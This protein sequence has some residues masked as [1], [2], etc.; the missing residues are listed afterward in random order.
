MYSGQYKPSCEMS[1][2][3]KSCNQGPHY[4]LLNTTVGTGT[5]RQLKLGQF[6]RTRPIPT[7]DFNIERSDQYF[8]TYNVRISV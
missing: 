8:K 4:S 3:G 1:H 6:K 5:P 2:N 7:K